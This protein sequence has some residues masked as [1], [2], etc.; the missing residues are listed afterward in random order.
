VTGNPQVVLV[1]T[2]TGA[3]TITLPSPTNQK[4]PI[5][6]VDKAGQASTNNITIAR[7]AAESIVGVAASLVRRGNYGSIT[8]FSDG[9][10][11]FA[12]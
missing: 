1:D 8:L 5:T 3:R 10:N 7:N 6:V 4:K 2:S 11:W 9:T 12:L